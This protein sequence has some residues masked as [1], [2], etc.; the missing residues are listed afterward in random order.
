MPQFKYIARSRT[1]E[2]I[3]GKVEAQD[4]RAALL[5]IERMGQVP[6]SVSEGG[7]LAPAA[8][9]SKEKKR[10]RFELRSSRAPR[11]N[12][13]EILLLTREL[14]D[15]LGSGMT[16]GNALHT[17]SKRKTNPAQDEIVTA[18][19]DEIVQGTSLSD[20]LSK[21]SDT[22]STL[23][24]SMVRAGEASGQLAEVLERLCRHFE[25]VQEARDKV[26]TALIYP[27]IILSMGG[28]TMIFSMI[29]VVPRFSAIFAELGSTLPL[30]TLILIRLSS[31]M[32]K[33][34]WAIAIGMVAIVVLIRRTLRT[35]AGQRWWHRA[36][37]RL[38]LVKTI[39]T[40][41]A[42]AHFARTLG[43][44]LANGVQVLQ[45]LS[46]V[47]DTVGNVVI[48]EAIRDARS[49]VT[50]GATISLP[51]AQG[52]IFPPLLTDMLAVGEESGDMS[53][54]LMH[55]AKRYDDDLDRSVKVFTTVLEPILLLFMAV[56]VGFVAISMLL[57]VFDLTSGLKV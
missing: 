31:I 54:A 4:R 6:V 12:L 7:A 30:P 24:V 43:T 46:I 5:Q 27:G 35:P 14:S 36:Q 34:G 13:R 49:R 19:R 11:M 17:L 10:F 40:A 52:K 9:K 48:A 26:I 8:D 28:L 53:G 44:L 51:L 42:F 21:W 50:D 38:P 16:L 2:K 45:A 15:L 33:Y 25:R 39:V 22:F 47:E 32:I 37:L 55:I 20:A 1:G 3:E 23:Y 29:F 18:L 56:L 57:A 41:N